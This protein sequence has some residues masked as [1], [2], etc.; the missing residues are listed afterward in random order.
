MTDNYDRIARFYDVDMAQ[1]MPFDD[2]GFYADLCGQRGGPVLEL[3]CG[4]GRIL[5]PLLRR[6]IDA[7]GIDASTGMLSVLRRKAA[8]QSLPAPVARMDIRNLALR[9]GFAVILCPYSLITY[10]T[11][12]GAIAQLLERVRRLLVPGGVFVVDA[13]VPHPVI[14]QTDFQPD[15]RRPCDGLTLARWKRI[16]PLDGAV[17]RIERRYQLIDAAGVI[18]EQID[19]AETIR[20]VAPDALRLAVAKAG[21]RLGQEWWNYGAASGS[22]QFFTLAAHAP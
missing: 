13:F 1:N 11:E 4:N 19:I 2:I 8:E 7:V 20:P 10:I 3:G 12:D 18:V 14:A 15:Y 22:G 9:P 17:N 6:G 21:L 16:R 5:L